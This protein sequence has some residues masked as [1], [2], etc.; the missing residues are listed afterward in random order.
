VGHRLMN[1]LRITFRFCS[2]IS[3]L[4]I[5]QHLGPWAMNW[6]GRALYNDRPERKM[7]L[8]HIVVLVLRTA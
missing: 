4:F 5:A 3:K 2:C 6:L 1:T 8:V 7:K